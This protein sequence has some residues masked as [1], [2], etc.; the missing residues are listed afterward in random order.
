MHNSFRPACLGFQT[1]YP[2]LLIK[3]ANYWLVMF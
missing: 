1:V 3:S 2:D